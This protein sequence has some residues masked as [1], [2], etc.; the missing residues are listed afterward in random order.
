MFFDVST[1]AVIQPRYHRL[2]SSS[3]ARLHPTNMSFQQNDS[4]RWGKLSGHFILLTGR[5]AAITRPPPSLPTN[6]SVLK[7]DSGSLGKCQCFQHN[8]P[9]FSNNTEPPVPPSNIRQKHSHA[10][11]N[12]LKYFP[13]CEED[14]YRDERSSATEPYESYIVDPYNREDDISWYKDTDLGTIDTFICHRGPPTQTNMI[15]LGCFMFTR[16]PPPLP[17]PLSPTP[18][19]PQYP[20]HQGTRRPL[21]PTPRQRRVLLPTPSV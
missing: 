10:P 12:S 8:I 20:L 15:D 16:Y 4:E 2:S 6:K 9:P 14:T 21:L 17:P 5:T 19:P 7:V 13:Q 18:T 1:Y 11:K 3:G